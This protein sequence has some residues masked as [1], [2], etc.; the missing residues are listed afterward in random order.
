MGNLIISTPMTLDG[1][2]TVGE[3]FNRQGAPDH[4]IQIIPFNTVR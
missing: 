3:W 1:V 4:N 2:M